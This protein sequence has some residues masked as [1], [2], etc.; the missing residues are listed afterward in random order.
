MC[1]GSILL[2]VT[3]DCNDRKRYGEDAFM[4]FTKYSSILILLAVNVY[5]VKLEQLSGWPLFEIS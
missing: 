3:L 5:P 1:L 2:F 4:S